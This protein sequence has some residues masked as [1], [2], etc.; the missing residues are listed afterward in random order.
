MK[1]LR[2]PDDRFDHLADFGFSPHY[3]EVSADDGLALR[4]HYVDEGPS[5]E[6]PI[7]LLHGNPTWSYLY[8]HMVRGLSALGHRVIAPDLVGFGKSDKPDDPSYF[9][10]ARFVDW[11]AAFVRQL[12]LRNTTL[13]GQD[14]GGIIGL[15]LL[16]A[17]PDRFDR[18][19]ASNTGLPA[20]QG[21]NAFMAEWLRFSQSVEELPVARLVAS[22]TT[23]RLSKGELAAYE[24]PFPDGSYQA[25]AKA[26]P[27]LIPLQPDNPGVPQAKA[28]WSY[29]E[30]FERP[31]LTIFGSEDAIGYK[32]GAHRPLQQRIPGAQGLPHEVIEGANH[33]IQEDAHERLVTVI[34]TFVEK[35]NT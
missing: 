29:L 32:A 31:F 7:L 16:P 10:M 14:W 15:N 34:D 26:F 17:L 13:F 19:V 18:V 22:G 1:V 12:N 2:T 28:T 8:R 5:E 6:A 3:V 27:L 4:M 20:G 23:R 9:T 35:A 21:V 25:A 33:F 24:A 11:T 30:R